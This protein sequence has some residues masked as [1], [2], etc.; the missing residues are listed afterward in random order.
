MSGPPAPDLPAVRDADEFDAAVARG[1]AAGRG[2]RWRRLLRQ[3][4]L[5]AGGAILGGFA[6]VAVYSLVRFGTTIATIPT[7]F[8][9]ANSLAPPGPSPRHPLGE[10]NG[11]GIDVARSLLQATPFDLALI[12]GIVLLALGV[13]VFLGAYAGFRG[14]GADWVIT[15]AGD[16]IVGVPPFFFVLVLFIGVHLLIVPSQYL[17]VFGICFAAVLWPYYARPVRARAQ[18]VAREAYVEASR[19]SGAPDRRLVVH[20]ILPNSFYPVLAQVPVDVYNVFFVL[21][22]FQFIGCFGGGANGFYQ[23]LTPFPTA[24]FPEW[25]YLLASGACYGYN[26]LTPFAGWWMYTF[27]AVVIVLFGIGVMLVCDGGEKYLEVKRSG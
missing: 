11:I 6:L 25:G 20:H 19:A 10:M 14:G 9:F 26:V 13:G 2:A 3:P 18:Q 12:G 1:L 4:S 23:T 15:S 27:P 16:I 24:I 21:T 17:L 22:V 7:N 5:I 8:D